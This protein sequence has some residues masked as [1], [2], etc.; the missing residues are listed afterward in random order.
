[1][2]RFGAVSRANQAE[3]EELLVNTSDL[4]VQVWDSTII[5]GIRT[6]VEQRKNMAKGVSKTMDSKHLPQPPRNLSKAMD[7]MPYPL[8][9]AAIQRG[10]DAVK[11][12]PIA[13]AMAVLEAYAFAGFFDG[14]AWGKYGVNLRSGYDWNTNRQ[15]EDQTF[16]DLPHHEMRG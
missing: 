3:V 14:V 8:N 9:W 16:L 12:L 13:D 1:M 6:F 10:Y 11:R 2:P 7:I 5:D 15:F 4:V